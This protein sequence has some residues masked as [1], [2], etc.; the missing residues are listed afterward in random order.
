M[1]SFDEYV[2]DRDEAFLSLDETK[3]RDF[4]QKYGIPE[5]EDD[6]VLWIGVHK[7]I[8]V[9]RS[10]TDEQVERSKKWLQDHGYHAGIGG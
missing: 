5:P 6:E 8:T 4:M 2:K 1:N 10:A 3:I 7:I 9:I